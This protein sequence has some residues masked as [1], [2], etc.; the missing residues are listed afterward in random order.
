MIGSYCQTELGHGSN[1]KGMETTA[2]LD[3]KS[4]SWILHSPTISSTKW[5]PGEMGV[6]GT[7][8]CVYAKTVVD[9]KSYGVNSFLV[10]LRDMETHLPLPG[11]E[12]GD[13]GPK[14]GF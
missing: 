1:V 13:V 8:S 5:W 2:T 11:I 6:I 3:K 9:G 14:F 4:D 10:P 12:V 7:H